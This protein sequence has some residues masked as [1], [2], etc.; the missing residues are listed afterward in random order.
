[1]SGDFVS[2][3]EFAALIEVHPSRVSQYISEG[4]ISGEA[5]EGK[6]R[7][8]RI[9]VEIAKEQLRQLLDI[10]QR[11]GANAKARL[12]DAAPRGPLEPAPP[13]ID[14]KLKRE[15]LEQLEL[16]NER[17]RED[18]AARAGVYVRADDARREMG[19]VASDLVTTF[20]SALAEFAT[21]VA[22]GSNLAH[23]D[24]VHLLRTAWRSIRER[25]A[26]RES[27]A[28]A[29]LAA[30]IADTNDELSDAAPSPAPAGFDEAVP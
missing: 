8:A 20:E 4:K 3:S 13:T 21:A 11:I 9:R 6:G 27:R 30:V 7:H 2:K 22:A 15:R 18:R 12:D 16:A 14:D 5:I 1:M 26:D 23:R 29:V 19:R 17:A 24:A 10:D 25:S 28:V